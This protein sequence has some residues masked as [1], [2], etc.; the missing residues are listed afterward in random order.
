MLPYGALYC[1]RPIILLYNF[2]IFI[3]VFS[4]QRGGSNTPDAA[5]VNP[6]VI[7]F[8]SWFAKGYGITF[9]PFS[10]IP[11]LEHIPKNKVFHQ[12]LE[13]ISHLSYFF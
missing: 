11:F 10:P 2:C 3:L 1:Q 6:T 4:I 7:F 8:L 13:Y 12:N 9:Y 5:A